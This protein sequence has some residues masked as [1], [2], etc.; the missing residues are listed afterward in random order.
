MA[1]Q[2]DI[3]NTPI[4]VPFSGAYARVVTVSTTR[5]RSNDS[6]VKHLTMV[7][8]AIYATNTPED[9]TR[10]LDFRRYHTP[11]PAIEAQAGDDFIA[12]CYSYLK[13]LE[14]FAGAVDA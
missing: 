11:T 13:T 12:K 5:Q 3:T 9:D 1:I 7:D 2:L 6:G 4:G 8:V 14:D 10:A